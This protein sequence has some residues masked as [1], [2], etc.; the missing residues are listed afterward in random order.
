MNERPLISVIMPAYNAAQYIE[1]AIRSVMDQTL[2]D[3]ELL[4]IDDCS[5]DE[6]CSVVERLTEED[7]RV[8]LICREENSGGAAKV[9]NQGIDQC[10]GDYV[11][12]LDSDDIWLPGK[13]LAQLEMLQQA[14]ADLC[15]TSY[16]VIDSCGNPA[17]PDYLVPEQTDFESMLRENVIGCSTVLLRRELAQKYHFNTDFYHEDYIL[18]LQLLKDGCRAAGCTQVLTKWRY[19]ETSRSFNK[20]QSAK[21]RWKIY[22]DYLKLPLLKSAGV[23][24]SYIL[25]GLKKYRKE[26]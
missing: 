24:C 21:N 15:Y 7:S 4:V 3:W 1:E 5:A 19:I 10:R 20:V 14:G 9:R 26:A 8:R 16:A 17:K 6:T 25:S 13:L 23:F 22:R 11:A 12:F 2:T 18:W